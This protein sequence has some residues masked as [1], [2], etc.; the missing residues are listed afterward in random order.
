MILTIYL[1]GFTSRSRLIKLGAGGSSS[2]G[3]FSSFFSLTAAVLLSIVEGD[4]LLRGNLGTSLYI[5]LSNNFFTTAERD[6]ESLSL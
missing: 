4:F 5:E 6:S 1:L 3:S 2:K